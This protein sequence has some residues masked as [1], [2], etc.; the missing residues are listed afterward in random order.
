M[1]DYFS[2]SHNILKAISLISYVFQ[3]KFEISI[4]LGINSKYKT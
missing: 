2:I 4:I 1:I 3:K